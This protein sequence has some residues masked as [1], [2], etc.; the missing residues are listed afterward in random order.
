M[1]PQLYAARDDANIATKLRG[2]KLVSI[3]SDLI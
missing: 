3:L 1:A 2:H